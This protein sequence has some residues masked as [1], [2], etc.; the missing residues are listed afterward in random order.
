ME[1]QEE[2]LALR[3]AETIQ[4]ERN[5]L[6]S[7]PK[8]KQFIKGD[9]GVY[10]K[11][12]IYPSE[13]E[14]TEDGVITDV[15][16]IGSSSDVLVVFGTGVSGGIIRGVSS[17]WIECVLQHDSGDYVVSAKQSLT[18]SIFTSKLN[19]TDIRY[20]GNVNLELYVHDIFDTLPLNNEDSE[21]CGYRVSLFS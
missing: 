7:H 3:E 16:E 20:S 10:K 11:I 9:I 1:L 12:T 21:E 4:V 6:T 2:S 18:G 17:G 5:I 15:I 14:E 19:V 8:F 13:F